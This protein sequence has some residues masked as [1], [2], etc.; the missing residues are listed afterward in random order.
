LA[1]SLRERTTAV[2]LAAMTAQDLRSAV[3]GYPKQAVRVAVEA[4]LRECPAHDPE[5]PDF[6]E[7]VTFWLVDPD[8]GE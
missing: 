4:G 6:A 3:V 1:Q 2:A 8:S 5:A 7:L